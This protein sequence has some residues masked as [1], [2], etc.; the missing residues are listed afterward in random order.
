MCLFF[1]NRKWH[2]FFLKS[3]LCDNPIAFLTSWCTN[4]ALC[5]FPFKSDMKQ[6]SELWVLFWF[7]PTEH[8]MQ[9]TLCAR[10][11]LSHAMY[12]CNFSIPFRIFMGHSQ[13]IPAYICFCVPGAVRHLILL[14]LLMPPRLV[15]YN[16]VVFVVVVVDRYF[17]VDVR[18]Y[19]L[20]FYAVHSIYI[21]F[22]CF[23]SDSERD[24]CISD[25]YIGALGCF[26]FLHFAAFSDSPP[27]LTFSSSLHLSVLFQLTL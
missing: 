14:L 22:C 20:A 6:Q 2:W 10:P 17:S 4:N 3:L 18:R 1:F 15:L 9:C 27:F 7:L 19:S 11:F 25:A 26:I 16:S 21:R 12:W 23:K 24:N 13:C 8:Y 5:F